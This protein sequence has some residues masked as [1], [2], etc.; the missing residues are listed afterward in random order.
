MNTPRILL[1]DD[2]LSLLQALPHMIALRVH[3]VTVD[4][5][6]SAQ[7]ALELLEGQT[8]DTI[9][10]DIKMPGMDGLELLVQIQVMC[11]QI[12][13]LL[14][15]GHA[16]Q[17][18]ITQALRG[19]AY[20]FIQKP[21]D[22][23]YFV[24]ALHRALQTCEL[25]RQVQAQQHTL[26]R[27]VH[28][29]EHLREQ[30]ARELLAANEA[31]E[32]LVRDLLDLSRIEAN[33]LIFHRTRCDL[34]EVCQQV[35]DA[36]SAV[37]GLTLQF[38]LSRQPLE[39]EMDRERMSQVLITL[40]FAARKESPHG[41]PIQVVLHRT[42]SEAKVTIQEIAEDHLEPWVHHPHSG[43]QEQTP[44]GGGVGLSLSQHI[45]EHHG[46]SIEVH[47]SPGPGS[48]YSL[49]LPLA[50]QTLAGQ[51]DENRQTE[52]PSS[53]FHPPQWLLS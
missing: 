11:P 39:V 32:V 1:V 49:V 15:T 24:A 5:A 22:R 30:R 52:Q 33:R 23:V 51:A 20:D 7:L 43:A 50:T 16:D 47:R 12:P 19:G 45:V 29:L 18:L 10:S 21:I 36:Y 17:S 53:P 48:A 37:A 28:L 2:D 9:V 13:T 4:T 44:A 46:G 41:S 25:R 42:S 35:L 31:T 26:E 6:D 3:G 8:Y 40:L 14:I 38:E 34:A 27:Q